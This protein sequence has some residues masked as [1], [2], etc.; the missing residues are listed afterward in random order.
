MGPCAEGP[1]FAPSSILASGAEL[2]EVRERIDVLKQRWIEH[3]GGEQEA[4][5]W[6]E[7][8][9]VWGVWGLPSLSWEGSFQK[10]MSSGQKGKS[11]KAKRV[12]SLEFYIY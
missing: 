10:R 5:R 4:C 7:Y 3:V 6:D 11:E 1:S 9:H 12:W 2:Q 8:V